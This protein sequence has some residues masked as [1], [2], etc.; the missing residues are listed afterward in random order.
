M[1]NLTSQ[2]IAFFYWKMCIPVRIGIAIL[3]H[4]YSSTLQLIATFI[5]SFGFLYLYF[6]HSRLHAPEGG[7]IT[8]WAPYRI[9]H[10]IIWG[11]AGISLLNK[12]SY[13]YS[14]LIIMDALFSI[15]TT[16]IR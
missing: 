4:F 3:P 6:S 12:Q 2:Q 14:S 13:L 9:I 16:F 11:I 7:G 1:N 8:W 10:G 5:I 15:G